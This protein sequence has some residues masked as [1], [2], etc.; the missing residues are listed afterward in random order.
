M[1]LPPHFCSSVQCSET[2]ELCFLSIENDDVM[3]KTSGIINQNAE[4]LIPYGKGKGARLS[5]ITLRLPH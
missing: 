4:V 1:Q 3:G 2:G 5:F